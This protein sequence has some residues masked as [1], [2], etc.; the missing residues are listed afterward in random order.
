[1]AT[2]QCPCQIGYFRNNITQ[3]KT[4]SRYLSASNE[5]AGSQCTRKRGPSLEVCMYNHGVLSLFISE[6]PSSPNGVTVSALPSRKMR[7]SWSRPS[8][9]SGRSDLYYTAQHSD[10]DTLGQFIGTC[11][12]SSATSHTYTDLRP[13]TQYCIRVTAHN[14]V[15]DQDA[16]GTSSRTVQK[17]ETTRLEREFHFIKLCQM[18][19]YITVLYGEIFLAGEFFFFFFH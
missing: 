17:C 1:M 2:G 6:P 18:N 14:G 8:Q 10:P 16:A 5:R 19:S 15:S 13:G 12:S 3:D 4:C 9:S 11:L 7:V